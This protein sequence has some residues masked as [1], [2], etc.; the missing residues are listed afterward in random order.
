MQSAWFCWFPGL[1]DSQQ[2]RRGKESFI[3][4]PKVNLCIL[5][6]PC[7]RK[8]TLWNVSLQVKPSGWCCW[9]LLQF[10]CPENDKSTYSFTFR[11]S[12]SWEDRLF[13]FFFKRRKRK[14]SP[15]RRYW[16]EFNKYKIRTLTFVFKA[17][18]KWNLKSHL[19]ENATS[20]NCFYLLV[21]NFSLFSDPH[22]IFIPTFTMW[23]AHSVSILLPLS[24]SGPIGIPPLCDPESLRVRVKGALLLWLFM[25]LWFFGLNRCIWQQTL[26]M[27][28]INQTYIPRSE[29]IG[30]WGKLMF[31]INRYSKVFSFSF[32]F[33]N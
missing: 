23:E 16:F 27:Y 17:K 12:C 3:T 25:A 32:F 10:L 19:K 4:F 29:I 8:R 6:L 13:F 5:R 11:F 31:S 2:E 28:V 18:K 7:R 26:G 24:F 33:L 1:T 9:T 21:F 22:F 15:K 30:F 20:L 14:C